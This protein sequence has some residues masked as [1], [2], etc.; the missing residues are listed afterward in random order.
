MPYRYYK[1]PIIDYIYPRYGK[2][3]GGTLVEV[4]GKNFLNFDQNLRCAFGSIEVKAYYVSNDYMICYSPFSDVV[5]KE[6]PFS[7][8]LNNQQNTR[9]NVEY[10]Y[11]DFPQVARLE[12]GKGPDTGGTKVHIRGQYFNP[13]YGLSFN[14]YNDTMC[15]FG[16]LSTDVAEVVS[17]TE[18]IC[19]SPPSYVDREVPV[20]ITLN[21]QE[22]TSDDIL[23]HYYHPP[24]I[25]G[26]DPKIGPVTGGTTVKITGSNFADT[27]FVMCKFGTIIVKGTYIN[28]NE[29]RCVSPSVE[30]PGY[31][32]LYI[33]IR[34]D[35]FSSGV[36]T[37]YLYY[38]TPVINFLE[39]M[40]GPESGFT[41]ITIKGKNFANT[42]SDYVKCV[43]GNAIFTNA[44]VYSDTEIK[45]DS[46]SVLNYEMVNEKNITEYDVQIT[47]NGIDLSGPKQ[48]FYYYKDT[49]IS[50]LDPIYGPKSG[51]TTVTL[52][53]MDF[54]QPG[55]CNVTVRIATYHIK[56]DLIE[57][58][59]LVF[60]TPLVN[61]TGATVVQVAL[62]GRQFDK[63]IEVKNRDKENTF[64]YYREPL[65]RTLNPTKGPTNGGNEISIFGI[66]FDSVFYK[67]KSSEEKKLYYRFVDSDSGKQ[68]GE[69][70]LIQVDSSHIIKVIAPQVYRNNTKA[71]IELSYNNQNFDLGNENLLY[72]YYVLPNITSVKP[73]YGPLKAENQK[74]ELG[75]DNYICAD[76]CE[77]IVC[78]FR[79]KSNVYYQKATYERP[80]F[81]SCPAPNV[82]MPESYNVEASFNDDDFTNSNFN[83]TFY[84]PYV[85]RVV[86]QMVS[87]KGN[88]TISIYGFGFANSGEF[89]KA[90]YGSKDNRLKFDQGTLKISVSHGIIK[91]RAF[92]GILI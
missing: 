89:L 90:Q 32:N 18:M 43:F 39:P 2:K 23:F 62:N 70:S 36:N 81:V 8:S 24:L 66:G 48:K 85:I 77:N 74:I 46:P 60:T 31:V 12:P 5:Q 80:N 4:Y 53:G 59:K 13:T 27:G 28:E 54:T 75:L 57:K 3:N 37:K 73:E 30:R 58:E 87:T 9:Q 47:L 21:N 1:E 33:A 91:V 76:S 34:P 26:I 35:E 14:N 84:D 42:G 86:P 10:I 51:N 17:S 79:S 63:D 82:N 78:R 69:S 56:P 15:K 40:C 41:Q 64:Y 20:E 61:F 92:H 29:L 22:W 65:I 71:L 19:T 68:L 55:A 44:T 88:T 25:Y 83:Y 11:Y 50:A 49:F 72:T 67:V 38:D 6:L 16:K 45:C 7:I 52:S